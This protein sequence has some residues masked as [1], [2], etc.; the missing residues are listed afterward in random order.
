MDTKFFQAIPGIGPK[1]AKKIL[2]ELKGSIDLKQ[3]NAIEGEQKL[4][5]D[6]VKS[7]KNFGYEAETVKTLLTKYEGNITK[8]TMSEVIK[9]VISQI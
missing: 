6:I 8:E 4:F 1:S 7:L 3:I 9:R 2:I 5:K